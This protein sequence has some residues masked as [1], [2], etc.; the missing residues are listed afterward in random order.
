MARRR[1]YAGDM[2]GQGDAEPRLSS[3]FGTQRAG[4]SLGCRHGVTLAPVGWTLFGRWGGAVALPG[5]TSTHSK[6]RLGVFL[7]MGLAR[8][9]QDTSEGEAAPR[10]AMY[11]V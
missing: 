10:L 2:R 11:S 3:S 9:A 5:G 1:G 4:A 6:V 7:E 8:L